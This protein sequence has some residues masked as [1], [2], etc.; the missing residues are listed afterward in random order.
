VLSI[1]EPTRVLPSATK[2]GTSRYA[3]AA[4]P[5]IEMTLTWVS[6]DN[7]SLLFSSL[8]FSSLCFVTSVKAA[9]FQIYIHCKKTIK[10]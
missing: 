8:L 1:L 6:G 2:Q 4:V 7:S 9:D 3:A 5:K 10:E